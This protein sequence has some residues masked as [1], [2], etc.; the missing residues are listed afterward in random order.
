MKKVFYTP[1]VIALCMTL[2]I[3]CSKDIDTIAPV[4][5]DPDPVVITYTSAHPSNLNVVYFIPTDKSPLANYQKRI[6]GIMLHTQEWFKKEMNR[7]GYADKTF[8]LFVDDKNAYSIK[9][10]IINGKKNSDTYPYD[11]GGTIAGAEISEYFN[12]NPTESASDHTVVFMPSRTGDNGWDAG[13]VPFYGIGRWCYVLDYTNFDMDTWRN[14]TQEGEKNWIGGTIH[15]IG[16]ALN[17]PHNQHKVNDG[18]ISMMSWGNHEYNKTPND[19]HLT[20]ASAAILN[21]NQVFNK[22]DKS[23]FYNNTPSHTIKSLRVYADDT[24]L[25][26]KSKFEVT[27]P[28]NA[29]NIYNDPKTNS[30]DSNY[31]AISWSTSTII[32]ADSISVV[33][34]LNAFNQAYK[35]YPFELRVRFCHNNG[36]FSFENFQYN[37]KNG[38]PDIDINVEEIIEVDKSRWTIA[39]VSSEETVG[40]GNNGHAKHAIDGNGETFWHSAWQS[41]QPNYPHSITFNLNKEQEINGFTFLQRRNKSNG[42]IKT[43]TIEVSADGTTFESVGDYTLDNNTVKQLAELSAVKTARYFRLTINSGHDNGSGENVFF[44]FLAEVGIY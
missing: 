44:T 22:K 28:I 42:R 25:Y 3:G 16:H 24:N 19:V 31:N 29:V 30:T 4:D 10:T 27:E 32:N 18:W 17:L 33:M 7:N 11:G 1:L 15:E 36:Q 40:E 5:P 26:L 14:G 38:K 41:S 9:I 8:G 20:K 12:N 43:V 35:Q 37:F 34:P 6:S 21:N 39:D 23:Y 13:G 2:F